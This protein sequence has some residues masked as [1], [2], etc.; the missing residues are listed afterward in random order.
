VIGRILQGVGGV[1]RVFVD[2]TEF[3]CSLRGRI[4]QGEGSIAV[5][6]R[7]EIERQADG[8]CR[9]EAVLPRRTELSRRSFAK[10]KEQVLAANV[11]QLAAVLSLTRPEPDLFLLDRLLAVAE[12]NALDAFIVLNK[13]DLDGGTEREGVF[14][15]KL[16]DSLHP[17]LLAGYEVIPTSVMSGRGIEALR[18]RLEGRVTVFAGASGVGKSSLLNAVLPGLE[19]RV[20]DVGTRSGRGRHTTT[21]GQLIPLTE[22]S[23]IADTPGVQNFEPAA[24]EPGELSAVFREFRPYLDACRFANCRHRDEPGCA[25]R[26][27]VKDGRLSERRHESYLALLESAEKAIRPWERH[28]P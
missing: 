6:D 14:P 22:S 26:E 9:I 10:R 24:L 4:K 27:A 7:V 5:G 25:V 12:L 8:S 28:G 15:S 18:A 16:P 17:Y 20:G 19:L 3:E 11:D 2:G 23:F 13:M 21:A 1:Y